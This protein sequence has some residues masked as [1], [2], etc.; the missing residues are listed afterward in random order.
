MKLRETRKEDIDGFIPSTD[1]LKEAAAWGILPSFPEDLTDCVTLEHDG[2][3]IA[4]GG[5]VGSQCWFVTSYKVWGL[6]LKERLEFRKVVMAY[7]DL[8]L[9]RYDTL[10]N[11]V[12][13]GNRNHVRF[14]KSIGATFSEPNGDFMRFEITK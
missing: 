12:W 4:I 8:M 3:P 11:V 10:W 13:T 9:S 5:N 7:R 6:P 1:D 2:L 14:L